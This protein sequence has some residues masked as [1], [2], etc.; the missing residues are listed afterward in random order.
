MFNKRFFIGDSF[1]Q[2]TIVAE[3]SKRN[4]KKYRIVI[5]DCSCETKNFEIEAHKLTQAKSC[6]CRQNLRLNPGDVSYNA[7]ELQYKIGARERN[8]SW[9]LSREQFRFL[10]S[11]PCH[12]CGFKGVMFNQYYTKFGKSKIFSKKVDEEWKKQQTIVVNGIDR[13]DSKISYKIDNCVS[14]CKT[15]N[16]A[17]SDSSYYEFKEYIK[18]LVDFNKG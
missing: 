6:G 7:K 16:F 10:I 18:R 14:C 3:T 8:Y 5:C 9:D 2:L 4:N 12:Y 1:G 11:Q 15:C 13:L 17:K